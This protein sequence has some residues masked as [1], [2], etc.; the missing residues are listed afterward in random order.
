[1]PDEIAT[2]HVISHHIG[3]STNSSN[4][5]SLGS[6]MFALASA[7]YARSSALS[8][9]RSYALAEL[10]D[11]RRAPK[12]TLYLADCYSYASEDHVVVAIAI[13]ISNPTD[14]DNSIARAELII[15]YRKHEDK[16]ARLSV[17]ST[18]AASA[19]ISGE[20]NFLD[21][22]TSVPSHQTIAGL[23][24]FEPLE[25]ILDNSV[26]DDYSLTI[27]DSHGES[28]IVENLTIRETFMQPE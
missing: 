28:I 11:S 13:T 9:K 24:L 6:V 7:V 4:L 14:I 16:S 5:I 20:G 26:I 10:Q 15:A 17:A 8:A 23:L 2:M 25:V 3:W 22:P 1:M 27:I 21:P 18:T 19:Q 12:F